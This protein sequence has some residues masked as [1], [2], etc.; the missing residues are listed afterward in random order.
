MCPLCGAETC[1]TCTWKALLG[2][3][4][5][6]RKPS[7]LACP[8]CPGSMTETAYGDL[9]LDHCGGCRGTWYDKLEMDRAVERFRQHVEEISAVVPKF[10]L[11]ET[12][13]RYL[14]CP[15]C[16]EMMARSNF[17][18]IS[19]VMVDRCASC[20]I[21]LDGG[22]FEKIYAFLSS[23]GREKRRGMKHEEEESARRRK[24]RN[25]PVQFDGKRES[26][27]IAMWDLFWGF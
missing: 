6:A 2:R 5:T 9:V 21:W 27:E 18:Q 16:R 10:V 22:E 3:E 1:S 19:G 20:G 4:I 14:R 24:L 17:E 26:H 25:P 23:G 11:R 15:R 7:S 8:R 12:D 13:V